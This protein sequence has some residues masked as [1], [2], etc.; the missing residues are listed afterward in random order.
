MNAPS[1]SPTP[2][3]FVVQAATAE[4]LPVNSYFAT[5]KTVE[6]FSNASIVDRWR[7]SWEVVT[8]NH[9]GRLAT[10]LTDQRITALNHAGRLL[11]GMLGRPLQPGEDLSALIESFK[12]KKFLVVV[13]NGP[14]GGKPSVQSVSQP[15]EM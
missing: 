12:G 10:A 8:G 7:W 2:N 14:K 6:P 9:K 15:P 3:A 4:P 11:S 13:A 5:F 1:S